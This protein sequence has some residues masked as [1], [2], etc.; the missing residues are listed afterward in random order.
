ML[1]Y[2][3]PVQFIAK[4]LPKNYRVKKNVPTI[5]DRQPRRQESTDMFCHFKYRF[6]IKTN[7][8]PVHFLC[9]KVKFMQEMLFFNPI[10]WDLLYISITL[11]TQKMHIY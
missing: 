8:C 11:I 5:P 10:S 3:I 4:D 1:H 6:T 9:G 2:R 7:T